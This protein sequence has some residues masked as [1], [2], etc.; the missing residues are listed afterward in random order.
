MDF[1]VTRNFGPC[2]A[3]SDKYRKE[4]IKCF[5]FLILLGL[6]FISMRSLI[7]LL[8]WLVLPLLAVGFTFGLEE[9][10]FWLKFLSGSVGT[11][12]WYFK[13]LTPTTETTKRLSRLYSSVLIVCVYCILEIGVIRVG[14]F[15][16]WKY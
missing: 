10:A 15:D 7:C 4:R 5:S 16:D 6:Q 9:Y 13:N 12:E 2:Q 3:T 11:K 1:L 8:L 14:V